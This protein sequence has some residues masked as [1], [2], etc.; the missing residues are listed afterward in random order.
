MHADTYQLKHNE[1]ALML[2]DAFRQNV[3]KAWIQPLIL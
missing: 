2:I 1:D 3:C